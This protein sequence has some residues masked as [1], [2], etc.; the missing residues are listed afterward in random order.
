MQAFSESIHLET[1]AR[2]AQWLQDGMTNEEVNAVWDRRIQDRNHDPLFSGQSQSRGRFADLVDSAR[3]A[4]ER[5]I[6]SELRHG[7]LDSKL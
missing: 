4:K 7:Q 1:C 2:E 3:K 5:A 6:H